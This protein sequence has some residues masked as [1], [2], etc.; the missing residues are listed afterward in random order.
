LNPFQWNCPVGAFEWSRAVCCLARHDADDDVRAMADDIFESV[1]GL[2]Y[3]SILSENLDDSSPSSS[4]STSPLGV[5]GVSLQPA[6]GSS[7][8]DILSQ[9]RRETFNDIVLLWCVLCAVCC[10]LCTVANHKT[11]L[12]SSPSPPPPSSPP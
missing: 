6:P 3:R 12:S 10:V 8:M 1:F 2:E 7:V 11:S 9:V 5:G 4:S